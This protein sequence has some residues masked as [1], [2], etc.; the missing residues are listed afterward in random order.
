MLFDNAPGAETMRIK[1]IVHLVAVGTRSSCGDGGS[2]L[3]EHLFCV[4]PV[5]ARIC[6]AD[7]VLETVLAFLWHLL[8]TCV[9]RQ[10]VREGS[11]GLRAYLR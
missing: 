11:I 7:T 4:V 10:L 5:D 9:L 2:Q 6:D 3:L 8:V 1:K